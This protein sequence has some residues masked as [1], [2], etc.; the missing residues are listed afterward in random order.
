MQGPSVTFGYLAGDCD[1][2]GCANT[3]KY[4]LEAGSVSLFLC[5]MHATSV[6]TMLGSLLQ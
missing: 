1:C 6:T 4:R 3:P 2:E 5:H